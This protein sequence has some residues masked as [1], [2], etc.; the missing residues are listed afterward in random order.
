M[1]SKKINK[2]RT[3]LNDNPRQLYW[4]RKRQKKDHMP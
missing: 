2:E 4:K 3:I 1:K